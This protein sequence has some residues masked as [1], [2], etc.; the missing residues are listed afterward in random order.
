MQKLI[1]NWLYQLPTLVF[2]KSSRSLKLFCI[3]IKESIFMESFRLSNQ[4]IASNSGWI[5]LFMTLGAQVKKKL[6]LDPKLTMI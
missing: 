1:H 6:F 3:A 4:I 2:N 5:Q